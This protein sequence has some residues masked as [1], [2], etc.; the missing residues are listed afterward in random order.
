VAHGASEN[1]KASA[2]PEAAAGRSD[3]LIK[4]LYGLGSVAFGIKDQGFAF[5][6][7]LFYN[8]ALG[9]SAS[10]VGLA[11]MTALIFDAALDPV[12][13]YI[14]D[15]WRSKL[16][17]RHPF[18][19]A[20][21]LP[22]AVSYYFLWSP[23]A[24]LS[25]DAL[26]YYLLF[27]A[28]AVRCS[29]SFYE[30][31]SSAQVAELT[32]NYDQRTAYM[33][34][35]YFFGWMAPLIMGVVV[36]SVILKADGDMPAYAARNFSHYGLAAS[37]VMLSTILISAI[38]TQ[39]RVQMI[40]FEPNPKA[41]SL[42]GAITRIYSALANRA[43]LMIFAAALFGAMAA[44]IGNVL[45]FYYRTYFW[46]LTGDQMAILIAANFISAFVALPLAPI[47]S[48]RFGKV[49]A[50]VLVT[51]LF[52]F[53]APLVMILR[54]FEL[55]PENG[56]P[57][58]MPILF[59]SSVVAAG[60]AIMSGVLISSMIADVVEHSQ[61]ET[62]RRNEGLFF[63]AIGFV[64]KTVTGLGLLIGGLLL[65]YAQFPKNA[66]PGPETHAALTR[67]AYLEIPLTIGLFAICIG[68]LLRY[69]ITRQIHQ[70]NLAW[71]SENTKPGGAKLG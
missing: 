66:V 12:I 22:I 27:M 69:P 40:A 67:L 21:A 23:P 58:L 42:S 31:P 64:L 70:S 25:T 41:G 59:S 32:V 35:R 37:L 5:I 2:L 43:F 18:M 62:G 3:N 16:G 48:S 54:L 51:V 26:F 7:M 4:L 61:I 8:Q 33:S 17:R 55:M 49:R 24:G 11:L 60:L 68:F 36:F 39:R 34:V 46:D 10:A 29:L 71:L 45:I 44:G 65:D 15:N 28:I 63:A 57:L 13:G 30:V 9:L 47:L 38:G 6:L 52:V 14:S 56:T 1:A 53:S 20:A 19:Y 50:A